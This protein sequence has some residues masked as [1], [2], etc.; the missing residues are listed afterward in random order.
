[1][2]Y[3]HA[4]Q[5]YVYGMLLNKWFLYAIILLVSYLMVSNIPLLA[6]KFEKGNTKKLMPLILIAVIGLIA[7]ILLH[8]L[9][10]PIIFLSY[11]ILSLVFRSHRTT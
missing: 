8:W 7:A 2:I 4:T 11:I 5:S 9:A 10:V 1:M 6:L 3:W